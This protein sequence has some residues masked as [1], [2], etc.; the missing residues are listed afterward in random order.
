MTPEDI[1]RYH[2]R[3]KEGKMI[4]LSTFSTIKEDSGPTMVVRYN[5]FPAAAIVGV[6]A[7]GASAGDALDVME[8]I[9]H[10]EL[11]PQMGHEWTKIA[12]QQ[13]TTSD[14]TTLIVALSVVLVFLVLAAQYESGAL[15]LAVVLIVPMCLLCAATGV[16]FAEQYINIFTMIGLVVLVGLASKNA[17]L[18]RRVRESEAKGWSKHFR[19]GRGGMPVAPAS[20]H[21]DLVRIH[22]RRA[23]AGDLA[24]RRRGDAPRP[25]HGR[26]PRQVGRDVLRHLSDAGVLLRVAVLRETG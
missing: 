1:G 12:Y 21:D 7:P 26:L 5:M 18:N 6:P 25:W 4:A 20:N 22:P 2:V 17:I 14:T 19:R 13:K 24:R 8:Q 10:K 15:P 23:A 3:N 9:A 11:P 16:A